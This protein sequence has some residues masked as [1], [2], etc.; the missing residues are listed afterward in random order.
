MT[1]ERLARRR[2]Q[3]PATGPSLSKVESERQ[4]AVRLLR[5]AVPLAFLGLVLGNGFLLAVGIVLLVILGLSWAWDALSLRG[6]IYRRQITE[7]RAFLG[8][9][10]EITLEVYNR[11]LL[12]LAW[13][14]VD[15]AFPVALEMEGVELEQ[16]R[17]SHQGIFRSF[18]TAGALQRLTRRLTLHCTARG[19]HVFGPAT[20]RTGD[21]FGLFSRRALLTE[22][23]RVIVYPRLYPAAAL[24]LPA[25]NPLG[26]LASKQ[27]LFE[28][29]LRTAGIRE[30]QPGDSLRRIHWRAMA[31][32]QRLLSRVYEPSEEPQVAIFLNVA[33]LARHWAGSIPELFERTVSVAGSLAALAVE[34]RL[35]VGLTAN[36]YWPGSDQLLHIAPGRSPDQLM[37]ILELLAAVSPNA[38][39]PIETLLLREAP[40]LPWGATLMVVTAVAHADLLHALVDLEQ[41]GRKIVLFTLAE[42][43][44]HE[45]PPG[46]RVFHLPHLVEGVVAPRVV[47]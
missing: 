37:H 22:E 13:L 27:R 33:T 28:D 44:P 35:P 4:S 39:T 5:L 12:P 7:S 40:R 29:P 15:D 45:L 31:K 30:W 34:E 26:N 10:L 47:A 19:Y 20:L 23:L 1:D 21:G 18:W 32:H 6:L 16:F 14:Q 42:E 2:P 38:V 11:K 3:P 9:T 41:A 17:L 25:K 46:L 36:A 43:P 8:E 24:R